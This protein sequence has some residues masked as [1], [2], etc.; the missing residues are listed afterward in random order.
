M[1][2]I[3]FALDRLHK[4]R[5]LLPA[6]Q[7]AIRIRHVH[8]LVMR[9]LA[10]G[11]GRSE[12][13][14]QHAGLLTHRIRHDRDLRFEERIRGLRWHVDARAAPIEF[15][16]MVDAAHSIFF[17]TTEKDRCAAVRTERIDEPDVPAGGAERDEVLAQQP[18]AQRRPIGHELI[19]EQ[20]RQPKAADEI[21]HRCACAGSRQQFVFFD[22]EHKIELDDG[23]RRTSV[24]IRHRGSTSTGRNFRRC[25]DSVGRFGVAHRHDRQGWGPRESYGRPRYTISRHHTRNREG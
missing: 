9:N 11:P 16:A 5:L 21:T 6:P 17:I 19:C 7:I 12:I 24:E 23:H 15:P 20:K 4:V 22:T 1:C 3:E 18:H 8:P 25:S 2:R 10:F 13:C 14:P